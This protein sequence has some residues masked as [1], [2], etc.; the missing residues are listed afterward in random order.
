VPP[1][2]LALER[3]VSEL[4]PPSRAQGEP[5]DSSTPGG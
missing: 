3:A 4:W 1:Y 2:A 5:R